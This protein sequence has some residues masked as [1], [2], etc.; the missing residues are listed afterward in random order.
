[1]EWT[2]LLAVL[3]GI[4]LVWLLYRTVR[5]NPNTF[6]KENFS[7]SFSTLG[8]LGLSLI[9]FIAFCIWLLRHL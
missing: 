6:S 4:L 2:K 5:A 7:K 1:M 3:A 8:F 9:A